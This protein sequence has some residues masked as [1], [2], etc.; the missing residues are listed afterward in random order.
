MLILMT[1]SLGL[2]AQEEH[3]VVS[4]LFYA[5]LAQKDSTYEL[6]HTFASPEDER[7]FW[8]DQK[9]FEGALALKNN[10]AYQY[11]LK[12]KAKHYRQHKLVCSSKCRHSE[13]NAK[14]SALY[15]DS[16]SKEASLEGIALVDDKQ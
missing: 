15:F 14:H 13:T 9:T 5:S 8:K 10:T 2:V 12:H 7:D 3:V 4:E 6:N 16:Y 1:F 11:Y